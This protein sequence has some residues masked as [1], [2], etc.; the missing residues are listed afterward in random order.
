MKEKPKNFVDEIK[1][2]THEVEMEIGTAKH[3]MLNHTKHKMSETDA[4]LDLISKNSTM[5][6]YPKKR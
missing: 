1:Q 3:P 6:N 2:L 4:L 5:S